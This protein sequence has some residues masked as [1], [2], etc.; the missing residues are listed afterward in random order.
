MDTQSLLASLSIVTLV[1]VCGVGVW[2][3][4]R[5][6]ASERRRGETPGGGLNDL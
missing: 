2:Q 6:R 4:R 1:A 5:V 3:W